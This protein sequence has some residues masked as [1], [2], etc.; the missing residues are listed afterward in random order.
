MKR[1][2]GNAVGIAREMKKTQDGIL[3]TLAWIQPMVRSDVFA[4]I[5]VIAEQ[6]VRYGIMKN[7]LEGEA[8]NA[9]LEK[10]LQD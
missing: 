2:R 7:A 9:G 10:E 6:S 8:F 1:S 5:Q 3:G 4:K